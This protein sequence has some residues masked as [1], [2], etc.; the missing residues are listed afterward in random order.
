MYTV[1]IL[2]FRCL[3][4]TVVL[5]PNLLTCKLIEVITN[6]ICLEIGSSI[7]IID[8]LHRVLTFVPNNIIQEYIIVAEHHWAIQAFQLPLQYL[9]L[10]FQTNFCITRLYK[11]VL[12]KVSS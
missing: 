2:S 1:Q 11:S 3:Q 10:L 9:N 12:G 7:L 8:E 5:A 6:V 4:T